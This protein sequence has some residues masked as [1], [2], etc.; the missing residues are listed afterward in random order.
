[1]KFKVKH[2]ALFFD[3]CLLKPLYKCP[4][5]IKDNVTLP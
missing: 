1:M 4:W 2:I 5:S 3:I